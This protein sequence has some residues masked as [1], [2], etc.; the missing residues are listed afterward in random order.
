G[1]YQRV[2]ENIHR[3]ESDEDGDYRS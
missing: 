2:R 1:R 3:R